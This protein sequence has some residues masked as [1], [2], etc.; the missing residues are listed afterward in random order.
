MTG[1]PTYTRSNP[2]TGEIYIP[3]EICQTPLTEDRETLRK[4]GTVYLENMINRQ[5]QEFSFVRLNM[6][7]LSAVFPHTGRIQRTA[8]S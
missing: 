7:R 2:E 5:G 6:T 1:K 4:G 8:G 3:K